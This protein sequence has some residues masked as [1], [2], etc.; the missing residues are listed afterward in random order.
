[1]RYGGSPGAS[2]RLSFELL[3]GNATYTSSSKCGAITDCPFRRSG[4]L[5]RVKRPWNE[6]LADPRSRGAE[7][8]PEGRHASAGSPYDGRGDRAGRRALA[9][10]RLHFPGSE[11]RGD[12]LLLRPGRRG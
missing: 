10:S 6:Q 9:Q 8:L 2:G 1:A 7:P 3:Y 12:V 4:V 11:G 5:S